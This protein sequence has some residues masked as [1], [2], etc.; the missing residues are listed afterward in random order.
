MIANKL[1][2]Y[3][4]VS[5]RK[6]QLLVYWLCWSYPCYHGNFYEHYHSGIP[7]VTNIALCYPISQLPS[8]QPKGHVIRWQFFGHNMV[9]CDI[10]N[11]V[12]LVG[13]I[14][15]IECFGVVQT[16]HG[17]LYCAPC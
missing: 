11:M 9:L 15:V 7:L 17:R 8:I 1:D 13:F 2:M 14:L 4:I 3:G 10:V 5:Y 16:S 12:A 6:E